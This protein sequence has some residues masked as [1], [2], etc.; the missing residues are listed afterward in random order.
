MLCQS[1][2]TSLLR[3]CTCLPADHGLVP[4]ASYDM[5]MVRVLSWSWARGGFCPPFGQH[6]GF[7]SCRLGGKWGLGCNTT[8]LG[9]IWGT[10]VSIF[11]LSTGQSA[12]WTVSS[13]GESL[14]LFLLPLG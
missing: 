11:H 1:F 9:G 5:G 14:W 6:F 13:L 12:Q 3:D 4:G 8:F 2:E 7:N 10:Y